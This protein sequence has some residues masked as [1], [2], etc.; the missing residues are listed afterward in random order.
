MEVCD[1]LAIILLKETNEFVVGATD[2][3]LRYFD[4]T[5]GQMFKEVNVGI[6]PWSII[7]V[8]KGK[9]FCGGNNGELALVVDYIVVNAWKPHLDRILGLYL[10]QSHLYS[11]AMDG[12]T[13]VPSDAVE[14]RCSTY[15]FYEMSSFDSFENDN[16]VYFG[17]GRTVVKM[18]LPNELYDFDKLGTKFQNVAFHFT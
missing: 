12:E 5:S 1:F 11:I 17:V 6:V 9:L 7:E 4:A 16:N 10:S 13:E 8:E 3:F 15:E 14:S 2:K 18:K